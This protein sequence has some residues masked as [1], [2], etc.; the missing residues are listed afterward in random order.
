GGRI[1]R[2]GGVAAIDARL[3]VGIGA[4]RI[5][6]RNGGIVGAGAV[7]GARGRGGSAFGVGD[8]LGELI[9]RGLA[10]VQGIGGGLGVVEG[11]GPQ[12]IAAERQAAIGAIDAGADIGSVVVDG[13]NR[14]GVAG[15][16]IGVVGEHVAGGGRI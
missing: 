2:E 4:V 9:G 1:A 11:V 5:G 7:D 16:D 3:G 6:D 13:R 8:C 10:L 15:V 14:L 12:A